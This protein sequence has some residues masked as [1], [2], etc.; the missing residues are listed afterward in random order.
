M[1]GSSVLPDLLDTRKRQLVRSTASSKR[2]T[3]AGSVESSTGGLGKPG[4]DPNVSAKTS[5]P[6]PDPPM[7]SSSRSLNLPSCAS[8]ASASWCAPSFN[9]PLLLLIHPSQFASSA[10]V[11]NDA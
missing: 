3:C 6:R 2:L 8:L 5:G 7:P 4:F 11:H 9:W 10:S 1:L